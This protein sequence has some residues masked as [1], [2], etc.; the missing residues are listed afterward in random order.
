MDHLRA[1][2]DLD[3]VLQVRVLSAFVRRHS[4]RP[5]R[6]P[7]L[8]LQRTKDGFTHDAKTILPF[9]DPALMTKVQARDWLKVLTAK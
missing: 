5:E 7:S 8:K 1:S 4:R 3:L 9:I 2:I 6:P